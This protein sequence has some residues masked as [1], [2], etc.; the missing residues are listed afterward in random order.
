MTQL[1]GAR[2]GKLGSSAFQRGGSPLSNGTTRT[3]RAQPSQKLQA[4]EDRCPERLV[5]RTG[6]PPKSPKVKQP[7]L[8]S[9]E[10]LEKRLKLK[11]EKMAQQHRLRD[12]GE[13]A[14]GHV[15]FP[16][17]TGQKAGNRKGGPALDGVRQGSTR[18]PFEFGLGRL[19]C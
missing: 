2:V 19:D 14:D 11:R 17:P 15:F 3:F 13:A 9:Q 4:T 16:S 12:K 8:A 5:L 18:D 10:R 6:S 7:S 1:D